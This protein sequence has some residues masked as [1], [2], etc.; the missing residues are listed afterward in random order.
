VLH[1]IPHDDINIYVNLLIIQSHDIHYIGTHEFSRYKQ[2]T[3]LKLRKLNL[4][5]NIDP[6]AFS[7][8]KLEHLVL[9]ENGLTLVPL[10]V[11]AVS[12]GKCSKF[13]QNVDNAIK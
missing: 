13:G 8:T 2:L 9:L 7:G 3:K 10:A 12:R 1:A 11:L 6:S 5:S 4:G